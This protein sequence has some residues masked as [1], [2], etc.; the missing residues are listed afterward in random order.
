MRAS[1]GLEEDPFAISRSSAVHKK[2]KD[3]AARIQD[4]VSEPVRAGSKSA[5]IRRP[6]QRNATHGSLRR[7]PISGSAKG[8][9]A[10]RKWRNLHASI[11]IRSMLLEEAAGRTHRMK[12]IA[13]RW[14]NSTPPKR[15]R[16]HEQCRDGRAHY[17]ALEETRSLSHPRP[18][19][20][21]GERG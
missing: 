16:D 7:G 21:A 20:Q 19:V 11:R 15:T 14:V 9:S 17:L 2:G 12:G 1:F 13:F 5:A 4:Q 6:P 3:R 8:A 18:F 10:I